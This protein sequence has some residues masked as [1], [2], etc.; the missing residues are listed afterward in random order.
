[1]ENT[2]VELLVQAGP[3]NLVN[4]V[5]PR[6]LILVARAALVIAEMIMKP[7]RIFTFIANRLNL[8]FLKRQVA[9]LD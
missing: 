2:P 4:I 9:W 5:V 8:K 3:I 1:M 7:R 6:T